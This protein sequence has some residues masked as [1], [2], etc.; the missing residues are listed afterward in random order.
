[1]CATTTSTSSTEENL[2]SKQEQRRLSVHPM[3]SIHQECDKK[4]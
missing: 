2:S 4:T 1:M 3:W